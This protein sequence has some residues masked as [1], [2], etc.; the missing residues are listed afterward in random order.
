MPSKPKYFPLWQATLN[1]EKK[2]EKARESLRGC[3]AKLGG[4]MEIAV[5]LAPPDNSYGHPSLVVPP[6]VRQK[7]VGHRMDAWTTLYIASQKRYYVNPVLTKR[8]GQSNN[9]PALDIR[10]RYSKC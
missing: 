10:T 9:N 6:G 3:H 2:W 5:R 8:T 1:F 4:L 7:S